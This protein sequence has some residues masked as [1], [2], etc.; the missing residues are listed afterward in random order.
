MGTIARISK[1]TRERVL[2]DYLEGMEIPDI[3]KKYGLKYNRGVYFI[4]TPL[5]KEDKLL[6]MKNKVTLL[7]R[8]NR[9]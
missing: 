6:H 4:L 2:Q 8:K 9:K 5:S 3:R 1:E 7:L